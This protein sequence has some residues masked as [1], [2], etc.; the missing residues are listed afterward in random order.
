MTQSTKVVELEQINRDLCI[1]VRALDKALSTAKTQIKSLKANHKQDLQNTIFRERY[2]RRLDAEEF[3]KKFNT[4]NQKWKN[5]SYEASKW[6]FK[7]LEVKDNIANENEMQINQE[8]LKSECERLRK[9]LVMTS[10][11]AVQTV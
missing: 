8:K 6:N 4:M 5:Q 3:N 7:L 11:A 9:P 2:E 1:R 10:D